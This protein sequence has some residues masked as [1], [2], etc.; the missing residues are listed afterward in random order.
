MSTCAASLFSV[1]KLRAV[2]E[3]SKDLILNVVQG[4]HESLSFAV[5]VDNEGSSAV[6]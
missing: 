3:L 1:D 6:P 4:L 2:I 5:G